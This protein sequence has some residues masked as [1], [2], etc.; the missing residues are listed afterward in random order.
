MANPNCPIPNNINPLSPTGFKLSITKLPEIS[1]FCQTAT[2][3]SMSLDNIN[4]GTP[5][6][7]NKVPG[8]LITFADLT[9]NF[10]I[11]ENMINYTALW[12][13]LAGLG[14]PQNYLQ[15]ES[16]V[17]TAANSSTTAS[18]PVT[19]K[20]GTLL[21]NFSDGSLV[22]L[23]SNNEPVKAISFVDLHPVSLGT[24][25]FQSNVDDI[26]YLVGSATFGYT[27]YTIS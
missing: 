12:N 19:P 8:E 3:P 23:G 13:W 6:S 20:F 27:Y 4:V 1:F 10:I 7:T 2:L 18:T 5:F 11:D 24:I 15:Y 17:K 16:L 14:F 9:V 21:G 26:Q 25:E 22:I